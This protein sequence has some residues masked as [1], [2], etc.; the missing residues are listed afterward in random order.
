[1][2]F[3]FN[4][5]S[6]VEKTEYKEWEDLAA[7]PGWERLVRLL[8]EDEESAT[9]RGADANDLKELGYWKGVRMTLATVLTAASAHMGRLEQN[10]I[11]YTDP[12]DNDAGSIGLM[13]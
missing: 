11:S 1:M 10:A 7:S 4:L 5:L 13:D 6:D 8:T 12:S 3:D 9:V 2:E